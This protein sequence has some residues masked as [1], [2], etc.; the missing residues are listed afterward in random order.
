M[1]WNYMRE[2]RVLKAKATLRAIFARIRC[3]HLQVKI[4]AFLTEKLENS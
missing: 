4:K 3:H 1:N 2:P